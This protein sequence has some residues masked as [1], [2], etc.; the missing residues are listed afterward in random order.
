[1]RPC[2]A[3]VPNFESAMPASRRTLLCR[4]WL[5]VVLFPSLFACASGS[6]QSAPYSTALMEWRWNVLRYRNHRLDLN[7]EIP[8]RF[9]FYTYLFVVLHNHWIFCQLSR[10]IKL[11][12]GQ[13]TSVLFAANSDHSFLPPATWNTHFVLTESLQFMVRLLGNCIWE[14]IV[15]V[16]RCTTDGFTWSLY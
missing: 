10:Q 4:T 7:P 12:C 11:I 16:L 15:A 6:I 8:R 14:L 1:M 3:C 5:A 9:S 2:N 13:S